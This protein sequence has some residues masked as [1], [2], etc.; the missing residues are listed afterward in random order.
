MD[1]GFWISFDWPMA[2]GPGQRKS[3]RYPLGESS[4]KR[5]F[6]GQAD[7]AQPPPPHHGQL[8]V[9][10]W[11]AP[12]SRCFWSKTLFA[13]NPPPLPRTVILTIKY[14]VYNYFIFWPNFKVSCRLHW[15][16]LK[17]VWKNKLLSD[18]SSIEVWTK[19]ERI[20]LSYSRT[21]PVIGFDQARPDWS[22]KW[23]NKISHLG[24]CL[25]FVIFFTRVKFL[26]NKIYTEKRQFFRVKSVQKN[27]TFSRKICRKCQF[28]ALNL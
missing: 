12:K 2:N 17:V 1:F 28:F 21:R 10:F 20:V 25:I 14:P 27:A 16:H 11:C 4:K 13:T 7:T 8:F 22:K 6:Y 19:K 26:E 5:I 23:R 15:H 18:C 24:S 3:M 9:I